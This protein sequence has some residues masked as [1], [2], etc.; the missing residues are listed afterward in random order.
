[1]RNPACKLQQL[2]NKIRQIIHIF[3]LDPRQLQ[4]LPKNNTLQPYNPLIL[5][6][7]N[8]G[9]QLLAYALVSSPMPN[10]NKSIIINN[11]NK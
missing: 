10:I 1:M 6:L 9:Q 2:L 4:A 3:Q 8:P 5:N 11:G 7:R